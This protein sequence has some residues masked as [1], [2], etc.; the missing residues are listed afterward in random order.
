MF[1]KIKRL[2]KKNRW[3]EVGEMGI[4][5]SPHDFSLVLEEIKKE[6]RNKILSQVSLEALVKLLPELSDKV[7][8]GFVSFL[9]SKKAANLL[10]KIS[11]DEIVDILQ[12]ISVKKRTK[13]L[14]KFSKEKRK[15][16][17]SL[18]KYPPK[19]AGGLMTTEFIALNEETSVQ[20]A[21]EHIRKEAKE[22]PVYYVYVIDK[23]KKLVGVLSL[24]QLILAYPNQKLKEIAQKEVVKVLPRTD[25]EE[26]SN[27]ITDY[28]LMALP[29]V[30]KEGKI[31]GIITADDAMEVMEEE[32]SEDITLMSGIVP[33]ES[34]VG[35]PA[36]SMIKARI[37]W[38]II[39]LTGGIVAAWI[40]GFFEHTLSSYIILAMFMPVLVYMSDAAGTQSETIVVRAMA[41]EP[42]F[43]IKRYL[44]R[45][46]KVGLTLAMICGIIIS[47][48]A[49][50]GWG[51]PLFG[52]IIGAS[53][54]L[55]I[56]VVIFLATLLPLVLKKMKIDPAM[57]T[58]P[59]A[60]VISDIVTLVIY[61]SVATFLMKYF[62]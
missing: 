47:L 38:L 1:E 44:L 29:V 46:V 41:L 25:Q 33:V 21:I 56:L 12:N 51:S 60:T 28:N 9:G 10:S 55:S 49:V 48:A 15:E 57:A 14:E 39:G 20:E 40:I 5:L 37:P 11:S 18:L 6:T 27:L 36:N 2:I 53:M 62:L 16:V 54:F 32:A 24:R 22:Y 3:E 45:E 26:V 17:I 50:L 23:I 58:G 43:R 35:V 42:K 4:K 61:F 31:L 59:F 7:K 52:L 34:L 19:T 13:I 8:G 30:D